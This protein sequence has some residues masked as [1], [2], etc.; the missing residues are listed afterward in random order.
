MTECTACV[1]TRSG[2]IIKP[3]KRLTYAPA[4]ELRYLGEMAKLDHLEL[5]AMYLS[6]R[7]MELTLVGFGVG[8][9]IKHTSKLKVLNCMKAMQSPDTEEWH[10]K[11]RNKKAQFDK[12]NALTPAAQSSLPPGSKILTTRWAMKMKSN[13]TCQ[14]RLNTREYKQVDGSNYASDSI[15]TP[16]TNPISMQIMFMLFY[17]NPTWMSA[18]INVK[19]AFLQGRFKNDQEL[20]VEVPDGFKEWYPGDVIPG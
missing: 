10:K 16:V 1:V 6:L 20:C 18:I 7:C 13:G 19:G 9:R 8:G 14:G 17:K 15:A 5:A 12:Y 2:Q 4:M 3:P 11:I